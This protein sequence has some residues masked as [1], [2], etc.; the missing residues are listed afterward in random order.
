MTEIVKNLMPKFEYKGTLLINE[1][2]EYGEVTFV[3]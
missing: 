1:L 3:H 2:D